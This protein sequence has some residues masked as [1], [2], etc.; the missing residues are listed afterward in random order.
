MSDAALVTKED[1]ALARR[2][3]FA[4]ELAMKRCNADGTLLAFDP[5]V[6]HF[7]AEGVYV[8]QMFIPAGVALVGHIHRYSCV[9]IVLGEI[10]VATEEG[11]KRIVGPITFASPAGVKRAGYAIRDTLWTTIH[12]NPDNVRDIDKLE[13]VLIVDVYDKVSG[14]P[15]AD[16]L[17]TP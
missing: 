8:R 10:E 9:N 7:F 16:L 13:A 17:E 11:K 4:L 6:H 3:I 14:E 1:R 12:M 5:P 2:E 15:R